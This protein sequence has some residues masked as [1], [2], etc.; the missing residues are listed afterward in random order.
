LK[1]HDWLHNLLDAAKVLLNEV[2]QYLTCPN[3]VSVADLSAFEAAIAT[4]QAAF[5]FKFITCRV[6]GCQTLNL[7]LLFKEEVWGQ[8]PQLEV[9]TFNIRNW[10]FDEADSIRRRID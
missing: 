5:L 4:G 9:L 10:K 8:C 2:V 1:S 7:G 3:S 6:C